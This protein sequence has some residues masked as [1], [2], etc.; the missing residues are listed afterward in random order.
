MWGP[1]SR[2]STEGADAATRHRVRPALVCACPEFL[3][4]YRQQARMLLGQHSLAC[5]TVVTLHSP[6]RLSRSQLSDAGPSKAVSASPHST[7][8]GIREVR[9]CGASATI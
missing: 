3:E 4:Q 6:P 7:C 9:S 8:D 1:R 5:S 2:S